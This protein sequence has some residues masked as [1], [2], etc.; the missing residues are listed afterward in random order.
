MSFNLKQHTADWT[1]G[2]WEQCRD[3]VRMFS[4]TQFGILYLATFAAEMDSALEV[5]DSPKSTS[6]EIKAARITRIGLKRAKL[7]ITTLEAQ[8]NA[9]L[10]GI[11]RQGK[12]RDD[13]RTET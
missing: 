4:T 9:K 2:D 1:A 10:R 5:I 11:R 7:L 8:C 13:A 6:D 3:D 12:E